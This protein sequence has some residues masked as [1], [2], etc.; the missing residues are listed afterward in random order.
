MIHHGPVTV[1]FLTPRMRMEQRL[2]CPVEV[3]D[4]WLPLIGEFADDVAA[5]FPEARFIYLRR[6][7]MHSTFRAN[8]R[9][10][11]DHH[12]PESLRDLYRAWRARATM[13]CDICGE[14]NPQDRRGVYPRC[15]LCRPED[16]W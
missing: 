8:I 6:D 16:P 12:P 11:N 3:G 10:P 14:I 7:I 5:S 1:R 15:R 2:G 13:I 4:G 9:L